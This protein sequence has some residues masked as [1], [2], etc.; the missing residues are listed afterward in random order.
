M[1]SSYA[2][3]NTAPLEEYTLTVNRLMKAILRAKNQP[4]SAK[5]DRRETN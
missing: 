2:P 1:S 3:Q 5:K 4:V